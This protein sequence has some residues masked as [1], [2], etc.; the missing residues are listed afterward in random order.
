[1]KQTFHFLLFVIAIV[2]FIGCSSSS[3]TE[4]IDQ[5][6]L[7]SHNDYEQEDPLHAAL[8][9]GFQMIEADIHLINGELYV[10]H[11]HPENIEETP[12]LEDLYLQPLAEVIKQ[13]D[14]QVLPGESL[15]F[16]LVI[17]VKTEAESTYQAL[18][19]TL[20]PY[21][22]YFYQKVNGEWVDGPIRLLISGNRPELDASSDNRIVFLDG[23]I[24]NLGMGY[25]SELYPL[26]SDNWFNYFT[27]DGEGEMPGDELEK[28]R[29]YVSQA[30]QEDKLIR[31][32]AT[33]DDENVW[34]TLINNG[35]DVIN[36][37]DIEGMRRFLDENYAE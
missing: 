18:L 21:S 30:H 17:D 12:L 26:I 27:W 9:L 36:V 31:F 23:R 1:M 5:L 11:D 7:W 28:L 6:Y 4:T 32:W 24:P 15:P 22:Q 34:S 16:Y 10:I 14:G 2:G 37:D 20:E 13:N 19:N 35:V 8:D 3:N 29:D 25:S 33:S